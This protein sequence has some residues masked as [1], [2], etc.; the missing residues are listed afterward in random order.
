MT[1]HKVVHDLVGLQQPDTQ[2]LELGTN[3]I[4]DKTG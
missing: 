4:M 2:I 3:L 1:C